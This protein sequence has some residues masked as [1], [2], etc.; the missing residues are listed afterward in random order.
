MI[1][2][3]LVCFKF[4]PG[5]SQE[6]IAKHMADFAALKNLIPQ[7]QTYQAGLVYSE[8]GKP[9]PEF[10]SLHTLTFMSRQ[11]IEQYF[12]HP[13]HQAFAAANRHNWERVLVLN[14]EVD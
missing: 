1:V 12:L 10:D 4:K 14:A 9:E 3:R 8:P 11:D 2:Q 6:D 5:T 7:I 13:A